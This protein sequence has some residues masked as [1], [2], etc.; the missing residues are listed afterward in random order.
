[1]IILK[2]HY[3]QSGESIRYTIT[4]TEKQQGGYE[5]EIFN[6]TVVESEHVYLRLS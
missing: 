2:I 1:M 5:S 6:T 3:L 4:K